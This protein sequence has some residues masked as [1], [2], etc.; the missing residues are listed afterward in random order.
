MGRFFCES[1]DFYGPVGTKYW[2]KI[3]IVN[4]IVP[5]R[6]GRNIYYV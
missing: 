5:S 4:R 1:K 6:T 3:G 2:E